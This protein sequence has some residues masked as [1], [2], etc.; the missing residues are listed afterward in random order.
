MWSDDSSTTFNDNI[1]DDKLNTIMLDIYNNSIPV[2]TCVKTLK[3]FLL[4]QQT[5]H[6][7]QSMLLRL[8]LKDLANRNLVKKQ[9]QQ[10]NIYNIAKKEE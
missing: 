10:K 6:L 3:S 9:L 4:M 5:Q 1:S 7:V 8:V 2:D